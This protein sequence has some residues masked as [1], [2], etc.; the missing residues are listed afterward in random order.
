MWKHF[1]HLGK[2]LSLT[3]PYNY[4]RILFGPIWADLD[5][6]KPPPSSASHRQICLT[7]FQNCKTLKWQQKN[8]Q[9]PKPPPQIQRNPILSQLAQLNETYFKSIC[10]NLF[11]AWL[12]STSIPPAGS[13]AVWD[14]HV[15]LLG[16]GIQQPLPSWCWGSREAKMSA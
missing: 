11:D 5:Q 6:V 1:A 3:E 9:K 12:R 16:G 15:T 4:T 13:P 2:T 7:E 14:R 10:S 8:P